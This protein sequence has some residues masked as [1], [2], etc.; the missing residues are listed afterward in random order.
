MESTDSIL[1]KFSITYSALHG[2]YENKSEYC[3]NSVYETLRYLPAV[4]SC[5]VHGCIGHTHSS[6]SR[7]FQH[8]TKDNMFQSNL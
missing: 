2:I 8:I 6:C 5:P 3:D 4:T 7:N 1:N